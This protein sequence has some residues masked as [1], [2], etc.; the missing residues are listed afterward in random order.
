MKT[1]TIDHKNGHSTTYKEVNG[2]WFHENTPDAVCN[3]LNN[4]LHTSRRLKIYFGDVE[5]GRDWNEEHDTIGTIGK[6][7]GDVKVPLLIPTSR[8]TG[9]G[10]ILDH[11]IVKIK[12]VKT[13]YVLYCADN[14]IAP[15]IQ[16]VKSDLPNYEYNLNINDTT[17]S[18]HHS[19]RS[20]E[21]LK[22]KLS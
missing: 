6:S 14:Y 22:N 18:R 1:Q 10:A 19:L 21:L 3:I 11:C 4:H 2:M 17:Y 7:G 15:K 13:G 12:E 16:I 8:S 20:A 5:T 9:G